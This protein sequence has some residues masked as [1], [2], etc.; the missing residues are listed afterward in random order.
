[1]EPSIA[2]S[3]KWLFS[4]TFTSSVNPY[5]HAAIRYTLTHP[6]SKQGDEPRY[7]QIVMN[8]VGKSGRLYDSPQRMSACL[9]YLL[10][11]GV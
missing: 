3:L 4:W 5:G 9:F 10:F 7:E 11:L 8:I 2:F 6:P 1:V